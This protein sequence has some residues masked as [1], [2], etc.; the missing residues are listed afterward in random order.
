VFNVAAFGL[1]ASVKMSS[2]LLNCRVNQSLVKFIPC[3][4]NAL[5]QYLYHTW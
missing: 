4:Q 1:D 2:A 3:R 5:M